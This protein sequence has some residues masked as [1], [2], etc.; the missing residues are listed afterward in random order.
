M[1]GDTLAGVSCSGLLTQP[2]MTWHEAQP[3][4]AQD[5]TS[6]LLAGQAHLFKKPYHI[7]MPKE[8]TSALWS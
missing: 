1:H 5:F 6:I 3:A 8:Y 4:N 2:K 7:V